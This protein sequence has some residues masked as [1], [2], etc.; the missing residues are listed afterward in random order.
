MDSAPYVQGRA[1]AVTWA[2]EH[3]KQNP[4]EKTLR[5]MLMQEEGATAAAVD[6]FLKDRVGYLQ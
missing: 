3:P 2:K 4:D 6:R 5:G 1:W